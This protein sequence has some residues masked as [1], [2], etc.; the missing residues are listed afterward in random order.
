MHHGAEY[1]LLEEGNNVIGMTE[2][3]DQNNQLLI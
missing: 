3:K 2:D 1:W